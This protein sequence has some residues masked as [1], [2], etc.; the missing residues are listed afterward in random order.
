MPENKDRKIKKKKL[1]VKKK[2]AKKLKTKVARRS[3]SK[4][5]TEK[6]EKPEEG[7]EEVKERDITKTADEEKE[8]AEGEK[9]EKEI[10]KDEQDKEEVQK[11]EKEI[12]VL[13]YKALN[14]VLRHGMRF[15]NPKSPKNKW[16]ECMG[17]LVGNIIEGK[18]EILDA[19]PMV[20]GNIVE[21]EFQ[22]EHYA[23]ADEINQ[24]LTD[25][26]WIVGWYHTHPGHGLFLSPV[27]KL[28][29]SGYQSLNPKAV[30]L[31]FDPSKF[32]DGTQ[33]SRY[34]KLFRLKAPELGEKSDFFEIEEVEIRHS[35]HEVL[36]SAVEA[37]MLMSEEYPLVL[38]YKEDYKKPKSAISKKAESL[39]KD[40]NEMRMAMKK[41][42]KEVSLL[43][44][45]LEKYETSVEES[46]KIVIKEKKMKKR[47]RKSSCDFCG[48]DSIMDEDSVC[49]NCG[50]NL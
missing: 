42:Y 27:D 17:F 26:N 11:K 4:E 41:M 31:V 7:E 19:I 2:K 34:L 46:D 48:Y 10:A 15:S 45:K 33:L 36:T 29:H 40:I 37:I 5:E 18:V 20:H 1:K 30:A 14:K 47:K 44:K 28:N 24:N 25:E 39:E 21:V 49:A 6:K 35:I 13:T 16:V 32:G 50:M 23:K 12:V 8:R 22:G 9:E 3:P 43:H 38:E